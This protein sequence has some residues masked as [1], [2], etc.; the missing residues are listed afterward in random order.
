MTRIRA[1]WTEMQYPKPNPDPEWIQ[2]ICTYQRFN[3]VSCLILYKFVCDMGWWSNLLLIAQA[4]QIEVNLV[5]MALNLLS[6][7]LHGISYHSLQATQSFTKVSKRWRCIC[8]H[9]SSTS[10]FTT[11]C[12]QHNPLRKSQKDGAAY[13]LANHLQP[14]SPLSIC[15]QQFFRKVSKRWCCIYSCNSSTA[16]LTTPRTQTRRAY[17]RDE[18]IWE[19]APITRTETIFYTKPLVLQENSQRKNYWKSTYEYL[20]P[21]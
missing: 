2:N 19:V 9:N 7:F 13:A 1:G 15:N 5:E 11:P 16:S 3:V 21:Y 20:L 10:S 8:S 17:Q 12:R 4:N 14:L 18:E 6:Q